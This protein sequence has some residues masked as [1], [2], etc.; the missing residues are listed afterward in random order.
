[1][2]TLRVFIASPS[3]LEPER[4]AIKEVVDTLNVA[5]GKEV[6][7]QI[8]L[9]GWEDILPGFGRPQELINDDVDRADVFVGFLWRRWGSS[10]GHP[11]YQSGFEEEFERALA[12]RTQS[13]VPE[14]CVFFKA[15]DDS[16]LG[17][18]GP[19]LR[20]VLEFRR[21]LVESKTVL[22]REFRD[23]ADWKDQTRDMLQRLLLRQLNTSIKSQ[24]VS[25]PQSPSAR[26]PEPDSQ[27]ASR[28]AGEKASRM[29]EEQILQVWTEAAESLRNG[30]LLEFGTSQSFDPMKVARIG[31]VADSIVNRD[32][33]AE[34]PGAHLLN[35]LFRRRRQFHLTPLEC[36]LVL[37]ANLASASDNSPGWFWI[38]RTKLKIQD[39]LVYLSYRDNNSLVRQAAMQVAEALNVSLL[40]KRKGNDERPIDEICSHADSETRKAGLKYLATKGSSKEI[41]LVDTLRTDMDNA[42]RT[43]AELTRSEILLREEP[44]K[45]YKSEVL[46]SSWI[47]KE[48]LTAL[49]RYALKIQSELL[50]NGLAHPYEK[51]R[52]FSARTLAARSQLLPEQI[53]ALKAPRGSVWQVYYLAR[54]EHGLTCKA[55]EIRDRVHHSVFEEFSY[56]GSLRTSVAPDLVMDRLFRTLS[57]DELLSHVDYNSP[58]GPIAYRVLAEQHFERFQGT[59]IADLENEFGSVQNE[60]VSP[61]NLIPTPWTALVAGDNASS[62]TAGFLT[63]AL[64]GLASHGSSSHRNFVLPLLQSSSP[65][66]RVAAVRA[67]RRTGL[68]SDCEM[69]LA[70]AEKE[71]GEISTE[72]GETALSL[73]PGEGGA[74]AHL[75]KSQKP[76]LLRLA[77]TSLG[78][79]GATKV[80]EQI[81]GRLYDEDEEVRMIVCAYAVKTLSIAQLE[82]LLDSYLS[83]DRYFYNVVFWLDRVLYAK[84][85]LRRYFVKSVKQLLTKAD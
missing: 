25:Q 35:L 63:A 46:T 31:L 54:I 18:A 30:D 10:P 60:D 68:P 32:I 80:W 14:I 65:T 38:R 19:Q 77:I 50:S 15:V 39:A 51:V 75:L 81:K 43:L 74:A 58:D 12:R 73:A 2:N 82:K 20:Q 3:D 34:L 42:V 55:K 84:L 49:E 27:K 28:T 44:S 83:K 7:W 11:P 36:V 67:L 48:T 33:E 37:K 59:I 29:G 62:R 26:N 8:E 4:R 21:K 61:E 22:F 1:M 17:D 16:S 45:F 79:H 72:A 41:G 52:L 40:T 47:S 6:T 57:Y 78:D 13:N 66:V 5:F 70:I 64:S 23:L 76:Q 71:T 53:E 85:P 69:L 56:S 9:L 24:E